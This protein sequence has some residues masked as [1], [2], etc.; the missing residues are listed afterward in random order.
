[1]VLPL[2]NL[3]IPLFFQ[4]WE[5]LSLISFFGERP[6]P[7]QIAAEEWKLCVAR[8]VSLLGTALIVI[9]IVLLGRTRQGRVNLWLAAS[10]SA[11]LSV[12]W[13]AVNG[14]WFT[15]DR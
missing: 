10:L 11:L 8:G 6:S 1:M 7:E 5:E 2:M 4:A 15:P 9:A 14:G 13:L 12:M 3:V